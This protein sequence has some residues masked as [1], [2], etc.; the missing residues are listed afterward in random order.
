MSAFI[1]YVLFHLT[2][3]SGLYGLIV[4]I[5]VT[6]QEYA[7]YLL[8]AT[9]MK[10]EN[11]IKA[12]ATPTA[13]LPLHDLSSA[14][15]A[16]VGFGTMQGVIMFGSVLAGSTGPSVLF[17]PACPHV[18]LVLLSAG[19][20]L[21][22]TTLHVVLMVAAFRAYRLKDRPAIGGIGAVHLAASAI[23]VLNTTADGC[24]A[25]L[26]LLVLLVGVVTA[27]LVLAIRRGLFTVEQRRAHGQVFAH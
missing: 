18:P 4:P 22:I 24:R 5:S 12:V 1:W 10:A 17:T 3:A 11:A 19:T 9:Y 8:Y 16:G 14:I 6:V 2:G 21:C 15:A 26:P 25:S 20:S 13:T 23:T 27:A 7:R